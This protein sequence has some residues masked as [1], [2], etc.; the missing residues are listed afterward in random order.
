MGVLWN[1]NDNEY[2]K[3]FLMP[4]PHVISKFLFLLPHDMTHMKDKC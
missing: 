4:I 3:E 2:E 1:V